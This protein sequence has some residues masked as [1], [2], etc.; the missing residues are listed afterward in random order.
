IYLES[1]TVV[2]LEKLGRQMRR[3]VAVKTPREIAYA[4]P[5]SFPGCRKIKAEPAACCGACRQL[6]LR[7]RPRRCQLFLPR[8]GHGKK[9]DRRG[10]CGGARRQVA[11]QPLPQ[12][13]NA[14]PVADVLAQMDQ[15]VQGLEV[16]GLE[17]Q[18]ALVAGDR[19]VE[20]ASELE[21]FSELMV[22]GGITG[23]DFQRSSIAGSGGLEI[24]RFPVHAGEGN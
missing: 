7:P 1:A 2:K 15:P 13:L 16:I 10:P 8:R 19:L 9:C 6:T 22:R 14:G 12:L 3:C 18:R 5:A 21:R 20:P 11:P 4:H 24:A 17:L 23:G